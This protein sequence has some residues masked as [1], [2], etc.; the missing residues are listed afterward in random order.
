MAIFAVDHDG[1]FTLAPEAFS[2]L[3]K[4]LREQGHVVHL[5]TMRFSSE[6]V[7]LIEKYA[8]LFDSIIFT[9][10]QA[11]APFLEAMGVHA[12]VWFEDTPRAIEES[13]EEVWGWATPEGVTH[14][15]DHSE[16]R[17]YKLTPGVREKNRLL[18]KIHNQ[19]LGHPLDIPVEEIRRE[20]SEVLPSIQDKLIKFTSCDLSK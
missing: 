11:K 2:T 7:D 17:Q 13:A 8:C 19:L 5:V 3:V 6:G 9:N 10:R 16:V 4:T 1:M 20:I 12:H 15:P 18:E 14:V